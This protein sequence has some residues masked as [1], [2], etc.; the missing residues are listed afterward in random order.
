M[1]LMMLFINKML[2]L[3]QFEDKILHENINFQQFFVVV[4]MTE[5][6]KNQSEEWTS[7]CY[8]FTL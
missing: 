2:L 7:L 5:R 6:G 4:K 8:L 3:L 1:L